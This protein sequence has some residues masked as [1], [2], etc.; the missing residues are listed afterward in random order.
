[1]QEDGQHQKKTAYLDLK[2]EVTH[3]GREMTQ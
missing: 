1:M 2:D 3:T